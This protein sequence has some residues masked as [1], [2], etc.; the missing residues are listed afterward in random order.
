MKLKKTLCLMLLVLTMVSGSLLVYARGNTCACGG[1]YHLTSTSYSSWVTTKTVNCT[2]YPY[3]T[4][5]KQKREVTKNY[6]CNKC[7][8]TYYT[9][10]TQTRTVCH[11]YGS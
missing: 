1:T 5:A 10:S 9:K 11:G 6:K 7:G 4:D 3:G 8:N 2:H